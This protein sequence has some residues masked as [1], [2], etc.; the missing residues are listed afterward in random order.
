MSTHS[1]ESRLAAAPP[2]SSS[3]PSDSEKAWHLLSLL[4]SLG[5]PSS[6]LELAS[7]CELFP[8]PPDLI[9]RLCGVPGS[10]IH[11]ADGPLVT[12]SLAALASLARFLTSSNLVGFFCSPPVERLRFGKRERST[13]ERASLPPAKRRASSD[14]CADGTVCPDVGEGRSCGPFLC[15]SEGNQDGRNKVHLCINKDKVWT[16]N[17]E[18]SKMPDMQSSLITTPS[19][20]VNATTK[21]L[22]LFHN[23]TDHEGQDDTLMNFAME[24]AQKDGVTMNYP[25]SSCKA[26]EFLDISKIQT[27][28]NVVPPISY[29]MPNVFRRVLENPFMCKETTTEKINSTENEHFCQAFCEGVNGEKMMLNEAE[30][31]DHALEGTSTPTNNE[32]N[33]ADGQKEVSVSPIRLTRDIKE[34][35][36][37][38][39]ATTLDRSSE[40]E[41]KRRSEV[42]CLDKRPSIGSKA[43]FPEVELSG[44]QNL[45]SKPS[46]KMKANHK[47]AG[48]PSMQALSKSLE[49]RKAVQTLKEQVKR[50]QKLSNL[51]QQAK[52][53]QS[54]MCYQERKGTSTSVS[55][56]DQ[57][58]TKV[59]PDFESYIVEEE[60]GS[61]GYGTVY[62]ARRKD[63][64]STVAI[65]CPHANVNQHHINN[66]LKMLE[67]FGGKN[68]VIKYEGSFKNGNSDCFILEYVE[69]DRPE[70]LKKEID[71]FQ[72]RWYGYCLFRALAGL[73]K[74]GIVH[75]DV[76][77]GNFL[78]SSKANK[79]YLIDF[80]LAMD[81]QQKYGSKN[82]L[83]LGYTHTEDFYPL[84]FQNPKSLTPTKNGK[85]TRAKSLSALK[86]ELEEVKGSKSI[87]D[88]R[89]LKRKVVDQKKSYNNLASRNAI[90]SQGPDGSGITSTR[91]LTSGSTPSAKRLREP[92]PRQGR[93]ELI[94]LLH[95]GMHTNHEASSVPATLRKRVAAPPRKSEGKLCIISPMPLHSRGVAVSGAGL[96]RSDHGKEGPCV[97]TKGFRAPEVL[98]KSPHQGPKVDVWSAGV[99][100]LYLVIGTSPFLGDPEQNIKEIAKL[101]GSEDLWEVAKLHDREF[102]FPVDLYDTQSLASMNLRDWCRKNTKRPNFLEVL[103]ESLFD[104]VDRCLTVNPK[105]RIS[106]EEALR[107]EFFAPCHEELRKQKLLRLGFNQDSGVSPGIQRNDH[108]PRNIASQAR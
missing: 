94:N 9:R 64:G 57:L 29:L 11:L 81:L 77:P 78:Y 59:L 17:I 68:F 76:K 47:H 6:P 93:K 2:T 82:K 39:D 38:F 100:L 92:L 91:D 25:N 33:M 86:L 36:V 61:G 24:K 67:K 7:R 88:P 84:S 79:G 97:G 12:L 62:R 108:Q 42:N 3:S 104:L 96:R 105:A 101:R 98:L 46:A 83:K 90:R 60:E 32:R 66:E 19:L 37:P 45:L 65:K 63:D 26:E 35:N 49:H 18:R 8:A 5:R 80:N 40:T 75:R 58:E 22:G 44:M 43:S 15:F 102:S 27:P 51:K 107:H 30:N 28:G 55:L 4:L 14:G 31:A 13:L 87:V 106:A 72:L 23:D 70:V 34:T 74:Q 71:S 41:F 48:S 103:P 10:P 16:I 99:T 54:G 20:F 73:H 69:H 56:K 89:N 21:R 85:S 52:D 53:G 1:T 95:D 50:G